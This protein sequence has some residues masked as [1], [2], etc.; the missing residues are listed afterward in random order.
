MAGESFPVLITVLISIIVVF[1]VVLVG[2]ILLGSSDDK[3]D[4]KQIE[5]DC[6]DEEERWL[7]MVNTAVSHAGK[8]CQASAKK[9][10]TPNMTPIPPQLTV[11][12]ERPAMHIAPKQAL[13]QVSATGIDVSSRLANSAF[14]NNLH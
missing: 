13:D 10:S 11:P 3:V 8:S 14:Y 2:Y 9:D 6:T 7:K 4:I 5:C 1:A 12:S